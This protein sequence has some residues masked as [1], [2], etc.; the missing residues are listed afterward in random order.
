MS[1]AIVKTS[2]K[3][4]QDFR[5]RKQ[6]ICQLESESRRTGLPKTRVLENALTAYFAVKR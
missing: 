3:R 6:L 4:R 1:N 2:G 5:L